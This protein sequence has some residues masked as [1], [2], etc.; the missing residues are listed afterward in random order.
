MTGKFISIP[1]DSFTILIGSSDFLTRTLTDVPAKFRH[2]KI[3]YIHSG[4]GHLY[5]HPSSGDRDRIEFREERNIIDIIVMLE[6]DPARFVIL[7][8]DPAWFCHNE[9]YIGPCG[10]VCRKRSGSRQEVLLISETFDSTISEL[11]SMADK[12]VYVETRLSGS[13]KS[14]TDPLRYVPGSSPSG[15]IPPTKLKK[16]RQQCLIW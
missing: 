12:L 9:E 4:G 5:L 13:N 2:G 3:V 6:S 7:A 16:D 14:Y 10:Y 15:H 1:K 11:E 8:Y